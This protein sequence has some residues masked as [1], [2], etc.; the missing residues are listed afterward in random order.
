M[1][2]CSCP[3]RSSATC[4]TAPARG[5]PHAA[6]CTTAAPT[7]TRCCS[8][9]EDAESTGALPALAVLRRAGAQ[10][11]VLLPDQ[12]ERGPARRR[13]CVQASWSGSTERQARRHQRSFKAYEAFGYAGRR[14]CRHRDVAPGCGDRGA[15]R[16]RIRTQ[17]TARSTAGGGH[18]PH[19]F[20]A[21]AADPGW[22]AAERSWR[23]D[24]HQR[25][26]PE[27]SPCAPCRTT[28]LSRPSTAPCLRRPRSCAWPG[29]RLDVGLDAAVPGSGPGRRARRPTSPGRPMGAVRA[30]RRPSVGSMARPPGRQAGV[31]AQS[32]RAD[33]G[34]A[35]PV[36]LNLLSAVGVEVLRRC[37]A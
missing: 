12:P 15:D 8:G 17:F 34:L 16:H 35:R 21:P 28:R 3:P 2:W 27:R 19:S 29:G 37:P 10:E 18:C 5:S 24:R 30:G 7:T 31:D 1:R 36:A 20:E 25:R 9:T 23:A 6:R 33:P 22:T 26:C 14:P 4:M 32:L 13:R 11:P